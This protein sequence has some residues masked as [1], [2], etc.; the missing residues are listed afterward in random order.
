MDD[1]RT[2]TPEE[3]AALLPLPADDANK[4]SRGKLVAV[5]G[6]ARYPG[7]ACLAS[8]ASERMGAGYTETFTDESAANLVRAA[9]YSLVVRSRAA[10]Q[11]GALASSRPGK[12]CAYAV[13]SGFDV[14]DTESTRLVHLLLKHAE[15]PVLV[16]GGGLDA[17][18]SAKGRRLLK[19][20]FVRG[21][22]TV[23]TPHAGEAARLAAPLDLPADDPCAL[24]RL[25]ALSYGVIALVKGPITYISDG[26]RVACMREGTPALAKAGTGD[27]LAGMAGALLA[28]GLDAFDASVLAA[29][30]HARAARIAEARLTSVCVVAQDVVAAIPQAVASLAESGAQQCENGLLTATPL[31]A[32]ALQ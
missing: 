21:L 17:L 20:R 24:A 10:L 29:S 7:A 3:L 11:S 18:S 6:S 12:P 5:V 8:C 30:L 23:V 25:I 19:R 1:V 15:A 22:P 28:Q 27:V 16:D 31:H 4:Y 14:Q 32:S 2:Y 13:G 9:S 26:D